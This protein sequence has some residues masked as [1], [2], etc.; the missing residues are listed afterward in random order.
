[1]KLLPCQRG[2][3]IPPRYA[4]LQPHPLCRIEDKCESLKV[5]T[6]L[7]AGVFSMLEPITRVLQHP[8]ASCTI[9]YV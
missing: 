6:A 8:Q 7:I 5:M 4:T 3:E 1:M 2:G 9:G